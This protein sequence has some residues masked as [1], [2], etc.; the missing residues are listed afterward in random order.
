M[1]TSEKKPFVHVSYG[2]MQAPPVPEKPGMIDPNSTWFKLL[3][4]PL[5]PFVAIVVGWKNRAEVA[6]ATMRGF[7]VL[8]RN[9]LKTVL[10]L[11][12]IA[13][14]IFF[15]RIALGAAAIIFLAYQTNWLK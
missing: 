10:V 14:S 1:N 9:L 15:W 5:L 13:L 11:A 4:L 8:G 12:V 7:R 3:C 6:R 2:Y